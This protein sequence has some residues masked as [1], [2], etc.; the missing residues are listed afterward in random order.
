[1]FSFCCSLLAVFVRVAWVE[2]ISVPAGNLYPFFTVA[3]RIPYINP[4]P[5]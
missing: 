5:E 1:M 4:N 2:A 3:D